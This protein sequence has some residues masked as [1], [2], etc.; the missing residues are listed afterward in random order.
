MR[1]F[2]QIAF[3]LLTPR[4]RFE[5]IYRLNRWH[6]EDSVSGPGSTLN[7]T[8]RLR[9][10]LPVLLDQLKVEVLLDIPCGDFGW[11]SRVLGDYPHLRHYIG[12]DIVADLVRTN[13]EQYASPSIRFIEADLM[14]SALPRADAIISR[15]CF[16][17]FSYKDFNRAIRNLKAT[18]STFLMTSTY[19][20]V[21]EN[22]DII[23]G[24]YRLINLAL[25]PYNF[26]PPISFIL[27]DVDLPENADKG[28]QLNL[29][30]FKDLPY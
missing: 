29:W 8:S 14:K 6:S 5:R 25:P 24:R 12:A 26:P 3:A 4:Q 20:N 28:K 16:I 1:G 15:D 11:M 27:E 22:K 18:G 13:T 19:S 7:A 30:A 9:R 21:K 2:K 10:E 17:H 23:T